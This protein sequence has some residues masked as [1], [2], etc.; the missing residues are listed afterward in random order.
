MNSLHL[1]AAVASFGSR[2]NCIVF[3]LVKN[4]ILQN[5]FK[6]HETDSSAAVNSGLHVVYER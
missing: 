1:S 2:K 6:N 5:N 3:N 4:Y